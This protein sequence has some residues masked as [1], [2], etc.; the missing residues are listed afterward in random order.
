MLMTMALLW[1]G[2]IVFAWSQQTLDDLRYGRPRTTHVDHAVGHEKSLTKT[3]FVA[4]NLDGA[5]YIIEMPGGSPSTSRLLV[6]PRLVGPGA[7]LAP[8]SL[9]FPGDP[10][11]PD[12][13][14]RASG[15]EVKF[16]NTGSAYEPAP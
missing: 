3:H 1:I 4:M 6:G 5:V 9:S 8:V 12:L 11:H 13:L 10:Q 2:Q 15:I 7:D 16:R 14:V